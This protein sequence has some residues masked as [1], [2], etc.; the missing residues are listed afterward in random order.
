MSRENAA[1][2]AAA[3]GAFFARKNIPCVSNMNE[4]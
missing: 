3:R 1:L 2:R 4:M